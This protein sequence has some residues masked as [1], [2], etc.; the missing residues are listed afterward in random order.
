M[1]PFNPPLHDIDRITQQS[2]AP[3]I[4]ETDAMIACLPTCFYMLGRAYGFLVDVTVEEFFLSLDWQA[5]YVR[6][7]GWL[8]APL[9]KEIRDRYHMP[10]VS[11]SVHF[12]TIGSN[13]LDVMKRVGYVDSM[14]EMAAFENLI[15]GRT[16]EQTVKAGTPV[17]TTMKS[18]FG[19]NKSVHAVI[20]ASW[21][22][23]IVVL[24]D[25]DA[26]TDRTTYTPAEIRE[27]LSPVG[28]GS[29]ILLGGD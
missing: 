14:H 5:T 19:A 25:P 29:I 22:D 10:I 20:I 23:D 15:A 26:R 8:R 6:G 17:I 2:L 4:G 24:I 21:S 1:T 28:A 16:I 3:Y 7:T 27:Y 18:G 9:S 11:W 13:D 12:N